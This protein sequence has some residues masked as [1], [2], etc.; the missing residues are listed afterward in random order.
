MPIRRLSLLILI[1]LTLPALAQ[2]APPPITIEADRLEMSQLDGHSLYQGNVQLRQGELLIR[3]DRLAI[4][5][6]DGQLQRATADGSPVYFEMP[7]EASGQLV[8]GESDHVDYQPGLPR[9][10]L[11]GS[12]ILWRGQDEFQGE[13]IIY[14]PDERSVQAFGGP[15]R[16]ERDGRVRI[17]LQQDGSR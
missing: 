4:H 13:Q 8:R 10:E 16:D 6:L 17:I 14:H 3:S 5:H 2:Q 9:I 7:D 11:L 15:P 12:A 1:L